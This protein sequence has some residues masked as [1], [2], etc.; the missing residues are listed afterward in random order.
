MCNETNE[1]KHENQE[2]K[3]KDRFVIK[4]NVYLPIRYSLA[5]IVSAEYLML[6]NSNEINIQVIQGSTT[7]KTFN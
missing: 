4:D 3:K 5:D 6:S 7:T 2:P 1:R